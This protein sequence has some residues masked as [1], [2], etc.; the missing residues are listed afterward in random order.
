MTIRRTIVPALAAA[1]AGA[2]GAHALERR[3]SRQARG[4]RYVPGSE[5]VRSRCAASC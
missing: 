3:P 1:L 2:R 4:H 5:S